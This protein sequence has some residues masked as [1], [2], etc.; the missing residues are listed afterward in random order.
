VIEEF[1]IANPFAAV[2]EAVIGD[3][4]RFRRPD[5]PSDQA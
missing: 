5:A 3:A 4:L 2:I 1:R